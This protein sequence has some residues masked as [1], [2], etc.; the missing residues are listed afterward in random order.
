MLYPKVKLE[1]IAVAVN[2]VLDK[3]VEYELKYTDQIK[4]VH[5]KYTKSAKNLVHYLALRS[6]DITILQEKLDEISLPITPDSKS[7]ILHRILSFK[8]I[9]NRL[10]NVDCSEDERIYLTNKEAKYLLDQNSTS[11]LGNKK[12]NRKTY[13]NVQSI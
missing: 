2:Q 12:K 10:L 1:E 8:T 9:V 5:P 13:R 7:S 3:I 6:F 11:L 4:N